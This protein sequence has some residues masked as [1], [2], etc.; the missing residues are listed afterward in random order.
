MT[1]WRRLSRAALASGSWYNSTNANSPVLTVAESRKASRKFES[2]LDWARLPACSSTSK[3]LP[4][5]RSSQIPTPCCRQP[6]TVA[7]PM[8]P[9]MSRGHIMKQKRWALVRATVA[10]A[11]ASSRWDCLSSGESS[12][13]LYPRPPVRNPIFVC[14]RSTCCAVIPAHDVTPLEITLPSELATQTELLSA[15]H[16]ISVVKDSQ[17]SVFSCFQFHLFWN[18]AYHLTNVACSVDNTVRRPPENWQ[19]TTNSS[20]PISQ[21]VS[22]SH[23]CGGVSIELWISNGNHSFIGDFWDSCAAG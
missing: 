5:E 14:A 19:I 15:R 8:I 11:K 13:K 23:S 6:T 3:E 7:A 9:F 20:L 16:I 1:M 18:P 12:W 10:P 22:E 17:A 2:S 21:I 4:V